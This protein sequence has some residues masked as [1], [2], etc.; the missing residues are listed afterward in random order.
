MVI[1]STLDMLAFLCRYAW[2]GGNETAVTLVGSVIVWY[3]QVEHGTGHK[4]R[5]LC[6]VLDLAHVYR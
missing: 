5:L 3:S 6:Q 1:I 4:S 2:C